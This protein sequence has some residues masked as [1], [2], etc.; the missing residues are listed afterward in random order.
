MTEIPLPPPPMSEKQH[1]DKAENGGGKKIAGG[2][3]MFAYVDRKNL[4]I[5]VF[6]RRS[7]D[8]A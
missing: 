8:H 7:Y 2:Q 6:F 5:L 3:S 1:C 4:I